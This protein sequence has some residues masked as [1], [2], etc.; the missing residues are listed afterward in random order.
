MPVEAPEP[1][2][3]GPDGVA[4][5]VP[6]GVGVA[7]DIGFG[8]AGGDELEDLVECSE[9]HSHDRGDDGEGEA[10]L[11]GGADMELGADD[12]PAGDGGA[13]ESKGVDDLVVAGEIGV[14]AEGVEDGGGV[15]GDIVGADGEGASDH[16]EEAPDG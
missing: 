16:V 13:E 15:V 4:D 7:S 5:E 10:L 1:C 8:D 3:D 6:S 14:E 12:F 11:G 2:T 9:S